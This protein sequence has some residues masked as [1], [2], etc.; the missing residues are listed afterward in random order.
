[1]SNYKITV[2][3]Q[4]LKTSIEIKSLEIEICC[5]LLH[6]AKDYAI[7]KAKDYAINNIAFAC[8]YERYCIT[9]TQ[10]NSIAIDHKDYIASR[11]LYQITNIQENNN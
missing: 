5:R 11:F 4:D 10:W 2:A 9:Q 3:I 7:D 1:M 6:K 8:A